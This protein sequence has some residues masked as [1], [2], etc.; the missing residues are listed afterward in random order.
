MNVRDGDRS[1][2]AFNEETTENERFFHGISQVGEIA[3]R[4]LVWVIHDYFVDDGS[5]A[6]LD[7][8]DARLKRQ[9][10]VKS[11]NKNIER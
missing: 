6:E 11:Q 1:F 7:N 8:T 4:K 9:I 10:L 3:L 5:V 2:A